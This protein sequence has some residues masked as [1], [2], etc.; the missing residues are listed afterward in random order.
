MMVN[1]GRA[2]SGIKRVTLAEPQGQGRLEGVGRVV[3]LI[4][5]VGVVTQEVD[6]LAALEIDDAQDLSPAHHTRPRRSRRN[7]VVNLDSAGNW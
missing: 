1:S 6:P 2:S 3:A 4:G 7:H 5:V